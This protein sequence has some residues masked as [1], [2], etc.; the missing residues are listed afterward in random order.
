MK[1]TFIPYVPAPNIRISH[2]RASISAHLKENRY[3]R[4][5]GKIGLYL[6]LRLPAFMNNSQLVSDMKDRGA[7]LALEIASNKVIYLSGKEYV[8]AIYW[9]TD[10]GR[11]AICY[12]Y[13]NPE[14]CDSIDRTKELEELL[15]RDRAAFIEREQAKINL[16][17]EER[18]EEK[19]RKMIAE[20]VRQVL[21]GFSK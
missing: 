17:L 5:D 19:I 8:D 10:D 12:K 3:Y 4:L 11:F 7:M 13:K 20:E 14:G 16:E 1:V 6:P 9:Q 18:A 2:E 21:F 15:Q